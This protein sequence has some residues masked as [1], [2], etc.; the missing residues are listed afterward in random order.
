MTDSDLLLLMLRHLKLEGDPGESPAS[1]QTRR[2]IIEDEMQK[3]EGRSTPYQH[4]IRVKQ[5]IRLAVGEC[6]M[7]AEARLVESGFEVK[8]G[9]E[10]LVYRRRS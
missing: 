8:P 4:Q 10:L 9:D 6:G 1:R 2:G 7:G 5:T 3:R